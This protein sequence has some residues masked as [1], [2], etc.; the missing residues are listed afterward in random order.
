MQCPGSSVARR[1][2]DIPAAT[3]EQPVAGVAKLTRLAALFSGWIALMERLSPYGQILC[4]PSRA[5]AQGCAGSAR[6]DEGAGSA[7]SEL[8]LLVTMRHR[9]FENESGRKYAVGHENC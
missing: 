5:I 4:L 7:L 3:E 1:E 9:R 2:A 6:G 8:P